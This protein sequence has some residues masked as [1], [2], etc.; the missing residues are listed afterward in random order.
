M[1][2]IVIHCAAL[3]VEAMALWPFILV[4]EK[5][6][7][8]NAILINHELI[9]LRQQVEMLLLPFYIAYVVNYLFNLIRYRDR[10]KAYREII[11]EREAYKMERD[12]EY[13]TKRKLW[14]WM[15]Y[16]G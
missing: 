3:D 14:A 2:K 11:F 6:E 16:C 15:D 12:K 4:K 5:S 10:D 1:I 7:M 13:L 8:N 9:H